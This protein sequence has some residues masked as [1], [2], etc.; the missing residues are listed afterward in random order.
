VF[1]FTCKDSSN[2]WR[3]WY[4]EVLTNITGAATSPSGLDYR[5]AYADPIDITLTPN[6]PVVPS[7]PLDGVLFYFRTVYPIEDGYAQSLAL[8]TIRSFAN[9]E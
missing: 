9:A 3:Y 5:L 7:F 2:Y 8:F 1:Y 4:H 6:S